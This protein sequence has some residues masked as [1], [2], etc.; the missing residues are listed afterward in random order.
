LYPDTGM[1]EAS[2]GVE[3]AKIEVVDNFGASD[4]L[5]ITVYPELSLEANGSD[6]S[7]T[8]YHN[9]DVDLEADG[10]S[11]TVGYDYYVN[12]T[13]AIT[14]SDGAWTFDPPGPG[15][16]VVEVLDDLENSALVTVKVVRADLSI[17]PTNTDVFQGGTVAFKGENILGSASYSASPDVGYFVLSGSGD[18]AVYTAPAAPFTGT[19]TVTLSDDSQSK[20]ATVLVKQMD[21]GDLAI[22]PTETE[23]F[24][25]ETVSFKGLNVT[26]TASYSAD[27]NVG[28]FTFSGND[29]VY[30]AP[31][32]FTGTV[33][34]TLNDLSESVDAVVEVRGKDPGDLAIDPAVTYV[35]QGGSVSFS[36]LNVYGTA[37][38]SA[39]PNVGSF[40]PSPSGDEDD[41]VYTAPAASFTGTIT[42]TL[43]DDSESVNAF[44]Y[45]YKVGDEPDPLTISPSSVGTVEWGDDV[46][47][48]ASGGVPPYT[49]WAQKDDVVL[50]GRMTVVDAN[51]SKYEAPRFNTVEWVWLEDALGMQKRVKVKVR[52]D[53]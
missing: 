46:T 9:E 23:V 29:A 47:F 6:S 32:D 2:G 35:L 19:V 16:Y 49:F 25:G 36:G 12:D 24:Q 3:I 14:S 37:S 10:G 40:A 13:F 38:Y 44:V 53:D 41:A 1:Y 27:P 7:I 30:T 34:V 4:L 21:A 48:R 43:T 52:E 50:D 20:T 5:T 17:S 18:A 22:T 39:N 26:G 31:A 33:I 15:S 8:V 42:V 28:S 45:V 51:R 11:V